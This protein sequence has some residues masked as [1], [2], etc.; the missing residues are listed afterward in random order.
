MVEESVCTSCGKSI[1]EGATI[2]KCPECEKIDII[3]CIHCKETGIRYECKS[4]K[5]I[6]PN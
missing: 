6:G 5:F 4:C 1:Q 2:F 3:R